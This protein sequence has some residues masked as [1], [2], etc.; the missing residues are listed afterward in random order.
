[1]D[2]GDG[3][4]F[5]TA[6]VVAPGGDVVARTR[7]LHIPVTAG[8]HE[9]RYFRPG[10]ATASVPGRRARRR[11]ARLSDVLGPMVPELARA[12]ALAGADV[13]VY[14]TAIGS[15]P[16]TPASTPSRCGSR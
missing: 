9:D 8:Y 15:E 16:I 11:P 7:K 4:G 5:N 6:V 3:L 14:P 10:P 13:I 1:M 12:Y 2:D